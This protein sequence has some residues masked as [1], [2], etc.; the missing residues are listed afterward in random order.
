[1]PEETTTLFPNA[2]AA[3]RKKPQLR[4]KKITSRPTV[5]KK[6]MPTANEQRIDDGLASIYQNEQGRMPDMRKIDI[7]KRH[8]VLGFIV[9]LLIIASLMAFVAWIGFFVL[10]SKDAFSEDQVS[11]TVE[12]PKNV[13]VGATTT[14]TIAY[15]NNQDTAIDNATLSLWY[16]AGFVFVTSSFPLKNASHNEAALGTLAPEAGGEITITGIT[17][18]SLNQSGSLRLSLKY[19]PQNIS[20]ALQKTADLVT[21]VTESPLTVTIQAPEKISA[22]SQTEITFLVKNIGSGTLPELRLAPIVPPNFAPA[23]S[24]PLLTK[25]QQWVIKNNSTS[26]A[27]FK[28]LSFVLRGS[29]SDEGAAELPIKAELYI[30]APGVNQVYKIAETGVQ[31]NLVKTGAL[32]S[33]AVNGNLETQNVQP[34]NTLNYTVNIKNTSANEIKDASVLL[35]IDGPSYKNQSILKWAAIKDPHDGDI[36]GEQIS[37]S[38]RHGQIS[39]NK[40]NI[41]ALASL[42]PGQELNIDIELPIK[43]KD[44]VELQNF[45]EAKITNLATLNYTDVGGTNKNASAA[46][47]ILLVNSDLSIETRDTVTSEGG[48]EKH[49]I[50]WLLNNTFHPLKNMTLTANVFGDIGEIDTS[51]VPAG[52]ATFDQTAKK[53]T[54]TIPEMPESVDVLAWPFTVTLLKKNPT[55]NTL[56]SKVTLTAEDTV[57]GQIISLTGNEITLTT[58]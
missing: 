25:D 34:G 14:Y 54:W 58:E 4:T 11:L 55:Q 40:K 35:A 42:K 21:T 3:P 57:T 26:T 33:V 41:P 36:K 48:Q 38:I 6:T 13:M 31:S 15:R 44:D 19:E 22:G 20:S 53:L 46:A 10:P 2:E 18:G 56:V 7:K 28:T 50:T 43:T 16:P 37:T 24:T 51:A 27:S 32:V 30:L 5:R 45:S 29:F 49:A 23:S 39:W 12:G 1:M 17:Y 47:L 52:T 9:A 8:P